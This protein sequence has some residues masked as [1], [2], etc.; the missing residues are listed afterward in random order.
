MCYPGKYL[1]G[2]GFQS[3]LNCTVPITI[4]SLSL[5]L[6]IQAKTTTV[7]VSSVVAV[8]VTTSAAS[9]VA[10]S[11]GGSAASSAGTGGSSIFQLIQAVQFMNIFGKLVKKPP[12]QPAATRRDAFDAGIRRG[13]VTD[14]TPIADLLFADANIE[15]TDSASS[16]FRCA[17]KKTA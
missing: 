10:V 3:E 7:M 9:S 4:S 15:A 6:Q 8:V 5:D 11:L 12:P 16:E 13:N 2:A 17:V 1:T 14:E